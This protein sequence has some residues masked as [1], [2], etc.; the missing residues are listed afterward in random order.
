MNSLSLRAAIAE[1]RPKATSLTQTIL[2]HGAAAEFGGSAIVDE[3]GA[4]TLSLR[5]I[6]RAMGVLDDYCETT[7][8]SSTP[9]SKQIHA[10]YMVE[11]AVS[12]QHADSWLGRPILTG[13]SA[14]LGGPA[15]DVRGG[16]DSSATDP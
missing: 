8:Y 11:R 3:K 16:P 6:V 5:T 1:L 12:E 15:E 14:D 10:Y 2:A 7:D 13:E 4:L 9:S